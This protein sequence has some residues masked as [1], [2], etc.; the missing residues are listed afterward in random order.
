[1]KKKTLA[2]P[3]HAKAD[4]QLKQ[5][6]LLVSALRLRGLSHQEIADKLAEQGIYS[7][8]RLKK[9]EP[10]SVTTISHDLK[11]I[12][13][14]WRAEMIENMDALKA[15]KLAEFREVK[16]AAWSGKNYMSILRAL[17]NEC[18]ILG[19]YDKDN[20]IKVDVSL[21]EVIEALPEEL[22]TTVEMGLMEAVTAKADGSGKKADIRYH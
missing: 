12:A 8:C 5:R 15:R 21:R 16:K 4:Y 7:P 11:I 6:R 13:R 20:R 22:R 1:M 10:L 2:R 17:E 19:L 14:E 18:K 3:G 9:E